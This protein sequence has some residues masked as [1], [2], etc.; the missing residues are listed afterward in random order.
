VIYQNNAGVSAARNEG[1]RQATGDC[2]TLLDDD[3]KWNTEKVARQT[4]AIQKFES[5]ELVLCTTDIIAVAEDGTKRIRKY[6]GSNRIEGALQTGFPP[7]STWMF[8]RATF[9]AVS[10]A[11]SDGKKYFFDPDITAGEDMDIVVRV[12][13]KRGL[14]INIPEAL[15][16][17]SLPAEG[18]VYHNQ[19][20]SA[21]RVLVKHYDWFKESYPPEIFDRIMQWYQKEIP[22]FYKSFIAEVERKPSAPIGLPSHPTPSQHKH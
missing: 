4:S 14:L 16:A 18:K 12:C 22:T 8:S 1:L 17:Y 3:D 11:H 5:T 2:F 13:K 19:Q 6:S 9:E 7:P 21:A 20:A 15:S 10:E